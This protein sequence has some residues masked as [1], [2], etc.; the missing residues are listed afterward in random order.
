MINIDPNH[1]IDRSNRQANQ[2]R[3]GAIRLSI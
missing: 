1:Q 3:T 2:H